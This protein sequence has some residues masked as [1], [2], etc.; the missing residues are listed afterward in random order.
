M[1]FVPANLFLCK[2]LATC[3]S[4]VKPG[5]DLTAKV[6]CDSVKSSS[7]VTLGGDLSHLTAKVSCHSVKSSSI[8]HQGL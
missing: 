7:T 1:F 2:V 3:L 6:S 8:V 4:T 5:G